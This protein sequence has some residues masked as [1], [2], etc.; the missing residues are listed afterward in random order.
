LAL[1]DRLTWIGTREFR[2]GGRLDDSVK[3]AGTNVAPAA[4]VRVLTRVRGVAEM[5]VRL[6]GDRLKAFVV[7]DASSPPDD[8][9]T[10]EHRL[11]R[12][13]ARNLAAPARPARYTFGPALPRTATGKLADWIDG[14]SHGP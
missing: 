1:P 12:V 10:L 7:P 5:A 14:P 6:D 3:I 9:A 8:L 11:R 4:I 2:L 13:A